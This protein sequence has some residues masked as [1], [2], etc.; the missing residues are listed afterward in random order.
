MPGNP[1]PTAEWHS[2]DDSIG[3][4]SP[5]IAVGK[6]LLKQKEKNRK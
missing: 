1:R 3:N 6:L 4:S 5:S 2:T